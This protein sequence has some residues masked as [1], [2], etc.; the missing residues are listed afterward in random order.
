MK[1]KMKFILDFAAPHRGKF[2]LMQGCMI[3][4]TITLVIL[5]YIIGW[6][7]DEVIYTKDMSR[8]LFVVCVYGGVYIFNQMLF[9]VQNILEKVLSAA[10]TFDIREELYIRIL[11]FKGKY[12]A[13]MYTGDVISRLGDD[14]DQIITM[15]NMN[16]FGIV[17]NIVNLL[18]ALGFLFAADL[19]LGV[20]TAFITPI[21]V[22]IS[23]YFYGKAKGINYAMIKEKGLLSSWTYEILGGMQEIKLL[24]ASRQVISEFLKR[25][26]KV[27]RLKADLSRVEVA[28]E[29]INAGVILLAQMILFTIAAFLVKEGKLTIGSATACFTYYANCISLFNEINAKIL[30]LSSNMVSC[31]R[32]RELFEVELEEEGEYAGQEERLAGSIEFRDVSFGYREGQDILKDLSFCIKPCEK[33]A[34]VGHSGVGKSTLMNLLCRIYDPRSGQILIDGKDIAEYEVKYLRRQIGMVHQSSVIFQGSVR[35]NLLFCEDRSRDEELWKAL[36]MVGL[37]E[38]IK[39]LDEELDTVIG[40]GRISFSGGQKQRIAIARAFVKNPPIMIF[41]ESTSSLDSESE[42][43]IQ[44]SWEVLG[45]DHTLLIIA[46]RLSTIMDADRILVFADG[47]IAGMGKHE[48]LLHTCSTYQTLFQEQCFREM[49]S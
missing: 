41:D 14:V 48:E 7:I 28:A 40:E 13:G 16:M 6:L 35:F 44:N 11:R 24:H 36:E 18:I 15:I 21:V 43:T 4:T 20:F 33:V 45:K 1:S 38:F 46:H 8:F 42:M 3:L 37:Y 39:S 30:A 49:A 23:R 32:V 19:W 26:I 17:A 10:F 25:S 5:P 12:L 27:F 9:T 31:E 2:A 47:R 29:R 34:V 22:Y